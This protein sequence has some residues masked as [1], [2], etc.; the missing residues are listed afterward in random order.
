MLS[1]GQKGDPNREPPFPS[2]HSAGIVSPD[3][4]VAAM[5]QHRLHPTMSRGYWC[6]RCCCCC[7]CCCCYSYYCGYCHAA[8]SCLCSSK[9]LVETLYRDRRGGWTPPRHHHAESSTVT[10]TVSS[11]SSLRTL[12]GALRSRCDVLDSSRGRRWQ[13][14][15]LVEASPL[16]MPL[17]TPL[18]SIPPTGRTST[19]PYC[20]TEATAQQPR[21]HRRKRFQKGGY[22][23]PPR[24][25][26]S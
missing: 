11:L 3:Q 21:H 10:W 26:R 18:H 14:Q 17:E 5:L 19:S 16:M 23:R 20:P 8:A 24:R 2:S 4:R 1:R 12:A 7:C 25:L 9:T 15:L 22:F 6:C 13:T